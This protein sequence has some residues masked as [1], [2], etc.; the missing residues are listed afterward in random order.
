MEP[1]VEDDGTEVFAVTAVAAVVVVAVAVVGDL[2]DDLIEESETASPGVWTAHVSATTS[3]HFGIG[4]LNLS[5]VFEAVGDVE[6]V[7]EEEADFELLLA[8][9]AAVLP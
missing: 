9:L 4:H 7:E 1:D 8:A 6:A 5:F 3:L 2:A